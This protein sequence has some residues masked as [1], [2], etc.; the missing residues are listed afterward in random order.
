ML[1]GE[2]LRLISPV[3]IAPGRATECSPLPTP[4]TPYKPVREE[5]PPLLTCQL[6]RA[7]LLVPESFDT[8]IVQEASVL[9]MPQQT[10]IP[11]IEGGKKK[12]R[13]WRERKHKRTR[14]LLGKN[15][16]GKI[17]GFCMIVQQCGVL[18]TAPAILLNLDQQIT[19]CITIIQ[20]D[21]ALED[22]KKRCERP[23]QE[24]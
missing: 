9:K 23:M 19:L 6:Q 2:C 7:C 8:K 11:G 24:S 21:L 13:G 10:F 14:I 4:T 3:E 16:R 22:Q 18:Q 17:Y 15:E 1:E 20:T 12:E 5:G